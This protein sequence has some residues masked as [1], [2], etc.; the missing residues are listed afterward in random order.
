MC[1][2]QIVATPAGDHKLTEVAAQFGECYFAE[3][4]KQQSLGIVKD[5]IE[6]GVYRLFNEAA[7]CLR[8]VCNGEKRRASQSGID[9]A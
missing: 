2:L 4:R 9:V 3:T 7:R 5:L 1:G 8:P 6:D